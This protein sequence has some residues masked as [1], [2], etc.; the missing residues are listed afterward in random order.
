MM[1]AGFLAF[2]VL[3]RSSG[4]TAIYRISAIVHLA[5]FTAM[6]TS[7]DVRVQL[8]QSTEDLE[9]VF[10][11]LEAIRERFD[12]FKHLM[13]ELR[14]IDDSEGLLDYVVSVLM[15]HETLHDKCDPNSSIPRL[16]L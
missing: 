1:L 3:F 6:S 5:E 13:L 8:L 7:E 12:G 16:K 11:S 4:F 9:S 2:A 15:S 10:S 14:V